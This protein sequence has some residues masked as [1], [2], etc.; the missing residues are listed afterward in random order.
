MTHPYF[1]W[2]MT[3]SY[4]A[5]M[6]LIAILEGDKSDFQFPLPVIRCEIYVNVHACVRVCTCVCIREYV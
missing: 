3:H 6:D 4:A 5:F 2:D 1:I